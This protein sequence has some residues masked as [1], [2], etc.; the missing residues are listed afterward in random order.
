MNFNPYD[1]YFYHGYGKYI[2]QIN[3]ETTDTKSYHMTNA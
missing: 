2:Y 1:K 3:Y